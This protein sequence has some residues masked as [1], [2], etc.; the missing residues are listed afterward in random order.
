LDSLEQVRVDFEN[1]YGDY[2][3][4]QRI[5]QVVTKQCTRALN[6]H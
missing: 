2:P 4:L 1:I 5:E 3:A 6:E